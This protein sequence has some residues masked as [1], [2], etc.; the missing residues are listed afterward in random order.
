MTTENDLI[1][2]IEHFGFLK[3]DVI[4]VFYYEYKVKII[5]PKRIGIDGFIL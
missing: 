5:C 4:F 3:K 1:G 2:K